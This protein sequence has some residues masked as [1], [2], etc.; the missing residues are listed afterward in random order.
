MRILMLTTVNKIYRKKIYIILSKYID[1]HTICL[2][3]SIFYIAVDEDEHQDLEENLRVLEVIAYLVVVYLSVLIL[4]HVLLV[5]LPAFMH[6]I[7][8][9]TTVKGVLSNMANKPY[10]TTAHAMT[11]QV[12]ALAILGVVLLI[13]TFDIRNRLKQVD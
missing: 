13:S 12:N 9:S 11:M 4:G 6:Y 2:C 3:I 10:L 5:S 7:S 1:N 8:L